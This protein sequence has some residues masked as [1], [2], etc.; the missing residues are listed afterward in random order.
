MLVA[1]HFAITMPGINL[2]QKGYI[3]VLQRDLLQSWHK[4]DARTKDDPSV[5]ATEAFQ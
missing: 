2:I 5:Y 1:L 3:P 4:K